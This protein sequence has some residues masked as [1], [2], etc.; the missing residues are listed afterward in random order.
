MKRTLLLSIVGVLLLAGCASEPYGYK[1]PAGAVIGGALGGLAGSAIG[2][3]TGRLAATAAGAVLGLALGSEAGKSLDRAD[4][5]YYGNAP[6][7]P[8]QV[9][10]PT[11]APSYYLAPP[12]LGSN[13]YQPQAYFPPQATIPAARSNCQ[14]L[15]SSD[16]FSAPVFACQAGNGGWFFTN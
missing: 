11:P 13:A 6:R 7:Y 9:P 3:G 1:Q 5:L 16:P 10:M 15:G 4:H 12:S 14:R 8:Q 2:G